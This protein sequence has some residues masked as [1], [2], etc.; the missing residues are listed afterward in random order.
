MLGG[1]LT[2][3]PQRC[4][5][6]RHALLERKREAVE[7]FLRDTQGFE[8]LEGEEGAD[9]RLMPWIRRVRGVAESRKQPPEKLATGAP[10]VDSKQ[11]VDPDVGGGPG[12]QRPAL[13]VVKFERDARFYC[14]HGPRPLRG[15]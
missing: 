10:V 8:A 4:G 3:I 6:R 11:D 12:P 9:P 7:R 1:A 15:D 2:D 13:N 5:A 14:C